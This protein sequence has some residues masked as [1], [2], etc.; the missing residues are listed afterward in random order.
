MCVAPSGAWLAELRSELRAELYRE[1]SRELGC[2]VKRM[3]QEVAGIRSAYEGQAR[4][5]P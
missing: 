4:G 1:L 2:E 5:N 3:A